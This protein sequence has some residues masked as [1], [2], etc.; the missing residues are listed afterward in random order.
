MTAAAVAVNDLVLAP[1][2]TTIGDGT[3]K[4]ALLLATATEAP[5]LGAA[6]VSV[7]VQ[8]EV[9][10]PVR[11]AGLQASALSCAEAGVRLT[12]AVV[13]VPFAVAVMV[14][15]VVAATVPAVAA[16]VAIEL[17]AATVT[18]AGTV[19]T[20]LLPETATS[21]P[22][23]G[24]PLFSVTVQVVAAPDTTVAGEQ[25]SVEGTTGATRLSEALAVVLL[26]VAVT[27]AVLSAVTFDTGAVK[28]VVDAPAATVTEA[29]VVTRALLSDRVTTV[30]PVGAVASS[31]TVQLAVPVP[32][33]EDGVQV[34]EVNLTGTDTG[35][36]TTPGVAPLVILSPT[37]EAEPTFKT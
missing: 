34:S 9:P 35:T 32:V 37:A 5:P 25:L 36:V 1:A 22:P 26:S 33:T 6:A 27:T 8:V 14:T 31:V 21:S 15:G 10:A 3:V 17:P 4:L 11:E 23:E 12:A 18:E 13:E 7:I 19:R 30:P 16:Y 2:N 29:G 28:L 24:A 20:A